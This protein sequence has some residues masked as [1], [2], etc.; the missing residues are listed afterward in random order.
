LIISHPRFTIRAVPGV[1]S[2]GSFSRLAASL[3]P[4]VPAFCKTATNCRRRDLRNLE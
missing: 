1:D 3:I 4:P 2:C